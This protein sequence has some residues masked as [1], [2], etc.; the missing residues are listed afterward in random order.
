MSDAGWASERRSIVMARTAVINVVVIVEIGYLFNCRSLHRSVLALGIFSNRAA[1]AGS[2]A[3]IGIQL[4]F[5]YTPL[6]HATF[7]TAA[8][9]VGAWLRI[10]AVSALSFAVVEIEKWVRGRA[11]R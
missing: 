4:F 10:A 11:T 1:I 5:T 2:I 8:I 9:D 6:M 3:M 7:H